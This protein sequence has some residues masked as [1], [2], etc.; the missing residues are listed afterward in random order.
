[1]NRAVINDINITFTGFV[2][3]I[4][5]S[6]ILIKLCHNMSNKTIGFV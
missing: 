2:L 3:V 4:V 6:V 5:I 1:M